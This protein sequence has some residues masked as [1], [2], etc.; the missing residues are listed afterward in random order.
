MSKTKLDLELFKVI[1]ENIHTE[2]TDIKHFIAGD[3]LFLSK[4]EMC[5]D[6]DQDQNGDEVFID[7]NETKIDVTHAK[8]WSL[9]QFDIGN[10]NCFSDITKL[11]VRTYE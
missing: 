6:D 10:P 7:I 9:N 2:N 8:D 3:R 4:S 1:I 11:I 5:A